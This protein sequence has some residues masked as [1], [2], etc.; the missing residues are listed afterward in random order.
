MLR[1]N[2]DAFEDVV[3]LTTPEVQID[4]IEVPEEE[5]EQP[6]ALTPDLNAIAAMINKSIIGE[7]ET[8]DLYNSILVSLPK[9]L[10]ESDK[11]AKIIKD[12]LDEEHVHIGQLQAALEYI[13]PNAILHQQGEV[14]GENQITEKL[15]N[16]ARASRLNEGYAMLEAESELLDDEI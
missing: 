9:N 10:A 13:T 8:V 15:L 6:A 12:I 14:E 2:E 4:P 11:V 7:V 1:L 5:V 3:V 16:V